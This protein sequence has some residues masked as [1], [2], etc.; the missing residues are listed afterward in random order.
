NRLETVQASD[1]EPPEI[2]LARKENPAF[3]PHWYS[4]PRWVWAPLPDDPEQATKIV[5]SATMGGSQDVIDM[6]RYFKPWDEGLPKLRGE[7]SAVGEI[8]YFSKTEKTT[9]L[10]RMT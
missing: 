10:A 3:A 9:L 4:R 5:N 8:E 7:L 6:P 1:L 2:A